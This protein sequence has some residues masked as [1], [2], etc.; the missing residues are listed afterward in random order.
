MTLAELRARLADGTI[1]LEE[2]RTM[3]GLIATELRSLH[4]QI[5]DG[6][7]NTEQE[8]RFHALDTEERGLGPRIDQAEREERETAERE[9]G[10][11][12]EREERAERFRE[13]RQRGGGPAF[14]PGGA[15]SRFVDNPLALRSGEAATRALRVLDDSR[16][17][18]SA[19]L[20]ARQRE[21][22]ARLVR[23]STG[24]LNGGIIARMILLTE[25]PAYRSAWAKLISGRAAV[26]TGEET[27][28]Y[29]RYEEA[30]GMS[31]G[32]SAE[33]G[34]GVPVF[35]DPTIILTGGGSPTS[36]LN[37]SRT[38]TITGPSWKGVTS[39]GMKW[40]FRAEGAASTDGSPTLA[41]PEVKA[42]RVDGYI[43]YTIE[44]GMDYPNFAGEMSRLLAV[45]Y[46][47]T[48]VDRLTLGAGDGSSEPFGIVTA[49]DANTNSEVATG[50]AGAIAAADIYGLWAALPQRYREG[51]FADADSVHWM[52]DTTVDNA[53]R[54]L[55]TV[56]PNFT[57]ALD[58]AGIP[59]LFAKRYSRN[60]YM[61]NAATGTTAA[62]LLI[63]GDWRYYLIAQRA[64]M[65]VE[66][67]Q[68]VIDTTT[69]TPTGER[70]WF[71]W[72]RVGAD[73]INDLA[74][75]MLQNK[76]T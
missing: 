24:D 1:T 43:P 2:L 63:V 50:T 34:Y 8:E 12:R 21:H 15:D 30:R 38:E 59:T 9:E 18:G 68:H 45:G 14:N 48:L 17:A 64:G 22:V 40:K 4:E 39:A 75:R 26:L 35:I 32:V 10:A 57:V 28:A 62:N 47:E 7:P 19:H 36:I 42:H 41:Q 76:V 11:R 54:Q 33:G 73:S 27:E 71:A 58:A 5:G 3:R 16:D 29:L 25:N 70:A 13:W 65:A 37:I 67:V 49:L 74:F 52:S 55:G 53:I 44:V 69:G 60:D 61:A 20:N 72:A 46:R 31:I 51:E 6:E 66:T 56:D 23:T